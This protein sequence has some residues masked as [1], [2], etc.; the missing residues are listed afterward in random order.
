MRP[1]LLCWNSPFSTHTTV[2]RPNP[3]LC[4]VTWVPED[5]KP[6]AEF[7]GGDERKGRAWRGWIWGKIKGS[8]SRNLTERLLR[9]KMIKATKTWGA[10]TSSKGKSPCCKL[11]EEKEAV[12]KSIQ[13]AHQGLMKAE[14]GSGR[15]FYEQAGASS[16]KALVMRA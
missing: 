14:A 4:P 15:T 11:A 16:G 3:D 2:R 6:W 12:R 1:R 5:P 7:K 13:L 8:K 9:G 10:Q